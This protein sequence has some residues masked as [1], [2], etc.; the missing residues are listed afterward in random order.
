MTGGFSQYARV[1]AD[2]YA[3]QRT[4][5]IIAEVEAKYQP[6]WDAA[7]ARFDAARNHVEGKDN[8]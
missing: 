3:K 2:A 7:M 6:R 8:V 5:E 1:L 4:A